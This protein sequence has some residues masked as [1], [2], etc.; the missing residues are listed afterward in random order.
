[1][2]PHPRAEGGGDVDQCVEGEAGDAP[3]QQVADPWL[4][5]AAALGGLSLP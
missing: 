3:S 4:G 1:M 2:H 5:Y